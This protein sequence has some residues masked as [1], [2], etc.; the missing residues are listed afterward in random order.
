MERG[1]ICKEYALFVSYRKHVH[2][3]ICV[4]LFLLSLSSEW[5]QKTLV[6]QS[7][8]FFTD[9]LQLSFSAFLCDVI[10]INRWH[11]GKR[12]TFIFMILVLLV[13][14]HS[15]VFENTCFMYSWPGPLP[16]P[17][18]MARSLREELFFAA[19]LM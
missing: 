7:W 1:K 6:E 13:L 15:D 12:C 9:N 14:F 17:P 16:P 3:Y 10:M 5:I 8:R 11:G 2:N 4:K 19:S 18:L